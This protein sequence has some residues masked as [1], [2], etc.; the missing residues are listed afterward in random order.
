MRINQEEQLGSKTDPQPRVPA[1]ETKASKLFWLKKPVGI[2]A[3]RKTPS[4]TGV[5]IGETHRVLERTQTHPPTHP[6]RNQHQKGPICLW[7]SEEV[8]ESLPRAEQAALFPL[9][10]LPLLQCRSN[11]DCFALVNI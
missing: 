1:Q 6:P 4:L 3:V 11:M 8:T 5:F 9:R 7:V 10:P 2:A